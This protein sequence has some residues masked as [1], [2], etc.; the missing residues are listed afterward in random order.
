MLSAYQ[1]FLQRV[2]IRL[3]PNVLAAWLK[4]LLGVKPVRVP[5]TQGSFWIDPESL[6]GIALTTHGEHEHGMV[7]TLEKFLQPGDTFVDLDANEGYFTVIG[8]R[9]CGE[10]VQVLAMEPPQRLLPVI[11]ENLQLNQSPRVPLLNAVVGSETKTS[12]A[13]SDRQHEHWRQWL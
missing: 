7:Q 12:A 13:A 9:H 2:L 8:A 4:P 10:A 3:R 6:L 1:S 11:E 5:T